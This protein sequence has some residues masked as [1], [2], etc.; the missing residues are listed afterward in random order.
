LSNIRS[1]SSSIGFY[2][3]AQGPL[4]IPTVLLVFNSPGRVFPSLNVNVPACPCSELCIRCS[5]LSAFNP[6]PQVRLTPNSLSL[7]APCRVYRSSPPPRKV[8]QSPSSR[9]DSNALL[10][11]RAKAQSTAR[12]VAPSKSVRSVVPIKFVL[13]PTV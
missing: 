8:P 2:R 11:L 5:L 13:C 12:V 1:P 10:F 3:T 4:K 7:L 6:L 9:L